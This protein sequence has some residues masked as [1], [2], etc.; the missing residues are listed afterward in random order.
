MC[1]GIPH[2]DSNSHGWNTTPDKNRKYMAP[3]KQVMKLP[4]VL[5]QELCQ[6]TLAIHK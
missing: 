4:F 2:I 3:I 1:K 5:Q 6:G